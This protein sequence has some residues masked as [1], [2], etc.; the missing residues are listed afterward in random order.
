MKLIITLILLASAAWAQSETY[1]STANSSTKVNMAAAAS[2]RPVKES[3]SAP[4]TCAVGEQYWNTASTTL[5]ACTATNTWSA[6]GSGNMT[7]ASVTADPSGAC[8]AGQQWWLR[9]DVSPPTLWFCGVSG[10]PQKVLST[11]NSGTFSA[12]GGTGSALDPTREGN[13]G[14]WFDSTSL[15][16]YAINENGV[17]ST[18]VVPATARTANQFVTHIPSTGIPATAAIASADLPANNRIRSFGASFD[19]GGSALTTRQSLP[20]V[21]PYACTI[22]AWNILADAGTATVKLWKVATG[23]AIPTISNVINTNGISLSTGT[24]VR[25]TTV[26]DFTTTS[27]AANDIVIFSIT[28]VATATQLTVQIQ[29][30]L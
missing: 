4:G 19:G 25:S 6:V 26:S 10:T 8:T 30:D 16:L 28:A 9:T 21:V 5:F 11:T 12:I 1:G 13:M 29:C 27:V 3:A 23:T 22:S 15:T 24:A 14:M 2:T 7:V 20:I 18:T 17:K